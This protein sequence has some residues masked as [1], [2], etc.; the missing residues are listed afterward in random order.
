[1]LNWHYINACWKLTT[2]V[3]FF[4]IE[5]LLLHYTIFTYFCLLLLWIWSRTKIMGVIARIHQRHLF[6]SRT[7]QLLLQKL[8][9][10]LFKVPFLLHYIL[11]NLFIVW[12]YS[13]IQWDIN[14][15]V[16]YLLLHGFTFG[17]CLWHYIP[18]KP[19]SSMY[20]WGTCKLF[21]LCPIIIS[22][23]T[24]IGECGQNTIYYTFIVK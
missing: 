17:V 5:F 12:P 22:I 21:I 24:T 3:D 6:I 4:I 9:Y 23:T 7:C 11:Y 20:M 10:L 1:M 16:S 13:E 18:L 15:K 8:R 19:T 14:Y 2:Y